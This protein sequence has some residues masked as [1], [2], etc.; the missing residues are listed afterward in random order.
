VSKAPAKFV[1]EPKVW[2]DV[3]S[4]SRGHASGNVLPSIRN[5]ET[6]DKVRKYSLDV[7]HIKVIENVSLS[8]RDA[9]RVRHGV[10]VRQN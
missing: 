3:V 9:V 8:W 5:E 6:T 4:D 7:G 2:G 1:P 10:L